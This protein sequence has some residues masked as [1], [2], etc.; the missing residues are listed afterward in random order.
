MNGEETSNFM[1]RVRAW[2]CADPNVP[3]NMIN[4]DVVLSQFIPLWKK[5]DKELEDNIRLAF[6]ERLAMRPDGN[7]KGNRSLELGE[8]VQAILDFDIEGLCQVHELK[9]LFLEII[10]SKRTNSKKKTKSRST[11]RQNNRVITFPF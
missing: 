8:F 4:V 11:K 5:Q 10:A 3:P 1:A 9:K 7:I 6:H 2:K